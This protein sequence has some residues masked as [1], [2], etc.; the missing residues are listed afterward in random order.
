MCGKG[1]SFS[2]SEIT[3]IVSLLTATDLSITDIA[4]RMRCSVSAVNSVNRRMDVRRYEGRRTS[5]SFHT[6]G[7]RDRR[8]A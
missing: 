8:S 3:R 7:E 5:W 6:E 4:K 2:N 1:R